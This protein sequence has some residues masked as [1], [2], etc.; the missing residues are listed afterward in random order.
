M[1]FALK[2][3]VS[4]KYWANESLK[5]IYIF[6]NF[7]KISLSENVNKIIELQLP[8]PKELS[9]IKNKLIRQLSILRMLNEG[10]GIKDQPFYIK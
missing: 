5:K 7:K 2:I 10:R 3:N 4:T 8:R 6:W 9:E 1:N